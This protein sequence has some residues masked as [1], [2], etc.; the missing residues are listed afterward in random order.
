MIK[1]GEFKLATNKQISIAF[2]GVWDGQK[3]LWCFSWC[4]PLR[5]RDIEDR[6]SLQALLERVHLSPASNDSLV[7][8]P[9]KSGEFSVKSMCLELAKKSQ[10]LAHDVIKGLCRALVPPPHIEFFIWL[11]LLGKINTKGKLYRI[12]IISIEENVCAL[13]NSSPEDHNHLLL[14]CSFSGRLWNWWINLWG[15]SWAFPAT[16]LEAYNQWRYINKGS[17]FKKVWHV[18]FFIIIWSLWKERNARIFNNVSCSADQVQYLI[19]LRLS[20]WLKGWRDPYPYS[21]EDISKNP[22]SLLWSL[23]VIKRGC[24]NPLASDV[25]WLPPL[26]NM[27]KWNVDASYSNALSL[28]A[29]G[30]VLRDNNESFKCVFST[31]IPAIEINSAEVLAIFRAIQISSKCDSIKHSSIII[32]SDSSN[33]VMWCNEDNGNRGI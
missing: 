31:P 12:G 14:H 30:G 13:C 24:F 16:L 19:L 27:L 21:Y 32:E 8:T 25:G 3:W 2:S 5:T 10:P 23:L 4:R 17:F 29:I 26:I 15:L 22:S 18:I 11:S 6:N 28:S 20:W 7:W 9:H 1:F 33:A